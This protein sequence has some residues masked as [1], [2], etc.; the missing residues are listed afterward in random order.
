MRNGNFAL[1]TVSS[2]MSLPYVGR[3]SHGLDVVFCDT[4]LLRCAL[5]LKVASRQ[6]ISVTIDSASHMFSVLRLGS[7]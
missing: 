4:L 7:S 2:P 3:W 6:V 1:S 5:V